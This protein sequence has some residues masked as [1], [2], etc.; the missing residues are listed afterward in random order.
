MTKSILQI[1][2]SCS[3]KKSA[4]KN[5]KYSRKK[6]HFENW[7]SCKGYSPCKILTLGH[8]TNH[9]QLFLAKN[10]FKKHSIFEK[11]HHFEN[12]QSWKGYSP[13]KILTLGQKLKFQKTCQNT[14]YKSYTIVLCKKLL[15]KTLNIREIR[16][17]ETR[18][19]CKGYSPC[20]ILTLGQKLKFQID[21]TNRLQL[22]CAKSV[23]KNTKYSRN[24]TILKIGHHAK[25][26]LGS[27]IKS[28]K[29][30]SKCILQII[31]SC[32][33][34][35]TASKNSQYSRNETILRIR[36]HPRATAH[37]KS[38]LWVKN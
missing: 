37:A 25:S 19:P 29:T 38:S 11:W 22:F 2:Y 15:Q 20:K 14:F 21:S 12:Q 27:K 5:T 16:H 34:Q 6:E 9:L 24:E 32:S 3:V 30:M 10:R 23:P 31:Y 33:V 17:F 26:S 36:H 8:S 28:A 18:S 13:C 1:I 7:P 4:L 35:K